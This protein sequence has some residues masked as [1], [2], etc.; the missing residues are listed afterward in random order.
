MRDEGETEENKQVLK[1]KQISNLIKAVDKY[2]QEIK[3]IKKRVKRT[4]NT[5]FNRIT[6][7]HNDILDVTS[8]AEWVLM[9]KA[10]GGFD[11][12]FI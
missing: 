1:K 3:K 2:L 12:S 11:K 6:G 5:I 8:S 7:F 4:R 10:F 9:G